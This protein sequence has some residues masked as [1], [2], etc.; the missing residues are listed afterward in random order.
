MT[1]GARLVKAREKAGLNQKQLAELLKVTPSRLNYWE[2]D[3]REPDIFMIKEISSILKISA[4]YLI[5]N[6]AP[7]ITY[8][9]SFYTLEEQ[10]YIKKYRIL[11]RHGKKIVDIILDEEYNR[12]TYI[13]DETEVDNDPLI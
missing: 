3:K 4:D 12:C 13:G 5:G 7:L 9:E 11:D 1:L 6:E 10:E 8:S 2:K